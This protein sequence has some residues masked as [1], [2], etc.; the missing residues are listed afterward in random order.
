MAEP[1]ESAIGGRMLLVREATD[2]LQKE[3]VARL[4][5]ASLTLYGRR[6]PRYDP[7]RVSKLE[8]GRQEPTLADVAIYAAVDP[9]RR[10]KL[11]LAW[12]ESAD[13]ALAAPRRQGPSVIQEPPTDTFDQPIPRRKPGQRRA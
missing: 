9:R 8:N 6:G 7:P 1:D 2:L 10:G 12:N 4:N 11:W 3:F 5:E 13:S